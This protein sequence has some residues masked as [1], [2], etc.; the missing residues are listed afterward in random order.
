MLTNR[1]AAGGEAQER[2][3]REIVPMHQLD[4]QEFARWEENESNR[5]DTRPL[6][7]NRFLDEHI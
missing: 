7:D 6:P 2:R 4:R 5:A 3:G 1:A